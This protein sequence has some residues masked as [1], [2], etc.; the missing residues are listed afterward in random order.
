MITQIYV[1]ESMIVISKLETYT[2]SRTS[3]SLSELDSDSG[4]AL[5]PYR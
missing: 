4:C 2:K 1:N 5:G 3:Q